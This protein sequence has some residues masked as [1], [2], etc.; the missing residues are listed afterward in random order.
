MSEFVGENDDIRN[1]IFNC[2]NENLTVKQVADI[3]KK[4]NKNVEVLNT[5][6]PVPNKGYTYLIK[7]LKMLDLSFYIK[8]KNLLKKWFTPGVI[9]QYSRKK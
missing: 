4:I 6:D 8:L 9:K 1:E 3:C 7:K 5:D 2:V